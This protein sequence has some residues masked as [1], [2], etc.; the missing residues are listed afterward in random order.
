VVVDQV[1]TTIDLRSDTV[2]W[3]T[4]EMRVAMAN[5]VV[6]D[7]VYGDDPTVI[8]LE[9][10][11]AALLEKPAALF[12]PSGTQ[13]N[14]LA[15]LCHCQPGDEV[16]LGD[17]SHVVLHECGGISALAGVIPRT[18]PVQPDGSLL[19]EDLNN[20]VR[21]DDIHY[22]ITRVITLENTQNKMGGVAL[23]LDYIN[24]VCTF[25]HSKNIVVH[26][27][28]AR[29]FNAA[30]GTGLHVS[31]IVQNVDSVTFCLSKALCA[32][33]GSM[34]CGSAEFIAK[35]RRKRKM[36]GG[37]MRQVGVLAAAGLIALNKMSTRLSE[38]HKVATQLAEGLS[39]IAG[40]RVKAN[41][42]N[43]V[44]FEM[45]PECKVSGKELHQRLEERGILT[46]I[47]DPKQIRLVTHYWVTEEAAKKVLLP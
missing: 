22:P 7:D 37:G 32:P 19:L 29:L 30:A 35:A 42:T 3:P 11:A 27:D 43:F 4:L 26:M 46:T 13:G 18:L 6:G 39:K 9:Q 8:K 36:L 40:L 5:A 2:S 16:I 20:A 12:I 10:E 21:P 28:G 1:M 45:L 17:K 38:D 34:L 31:K 44:F 14:L 47:G 25:A 23:S 41:N 15:M 33:A 24:S